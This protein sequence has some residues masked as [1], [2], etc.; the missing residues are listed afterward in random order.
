MRLSCSRSREECVHCLALQLRELELEDRQ[1]FAHVCLR[2]RSGQRHDLT[3][4]EI[5]EQNLRGCAVMAGG[6]IP[7]DRLGENLRICGE[8]P[9]ALVDYLMLAAVRAN[10][11]VIVCL[12]IESILHDGGFD[13]RRLPQRLQ[14]FQRVTIADSDLPHLTGVCQSLHRTPD[15]QGLW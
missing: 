6:Q 15:L 8:R 14:L 4:S 11:A 5:P 1:I 13:A 7:D 2:A 9:E 10:L 12:R 3:L